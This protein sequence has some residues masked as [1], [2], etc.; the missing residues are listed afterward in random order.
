MTPFMQVGIHSGRT[1]R[2]AEECAELF[3]PV[4]DWFGVGFIRGI[5][6]GIAFSRMRGCSVDEFASYSIS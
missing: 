5:L 3:S 1:C 2:S 6:E 4:A